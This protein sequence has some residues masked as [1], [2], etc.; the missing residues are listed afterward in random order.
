MIGC[1]GDFFRSAG[2]AA[3]SHDE[4]GMAGWRP[5]RRAYFFLLCF[6][7]LV[8]FTGGPVTLL[9][10]AREELMYMSEE[11]ECSFPEFR[12]REGRFEFDGPQPWYLLDEEESAVVI[13]TTGTLDEYWMIN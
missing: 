3:V 1:I 10:Q 7:I 8:F 2:M 4:A 9:W 6:T 5:L 13:D 12:L 11:L